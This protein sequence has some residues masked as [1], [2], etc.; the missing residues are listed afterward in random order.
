MVQYKDLWRFVGPKGSNNSKIYELEA[1]KM[2]R[3]RDLSKFYKGQD[4]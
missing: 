3:L 4:G 1:G 2:G